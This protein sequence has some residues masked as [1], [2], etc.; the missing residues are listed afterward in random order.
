MITNRLV[1][2]HAHG[3]TFWH[4]AGA[5]GSTV[6]FPVFAGQAKTPAAGW[7]PRR[8]LLSLFNISSKLRK[9][10]SLV[11]LQRRRTRLP[12]CASSIA[13][14]LS[15]ERIIPARRKV[16]TS[17]WDVLAVTVR[18]SLLI[19]VLSLPLL[20]IPGSFASRVLP[21]LA[22]FLTASHGSSLVYRRIRSR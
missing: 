16:Q 21:F 8:G 1:G 12:A 9:K 22:L 10:G 14:K 17:R 15:R 18:G 20:T 5:E 4:S 11:F 7:S 2:T 19:I 6:R 3:A 13:R